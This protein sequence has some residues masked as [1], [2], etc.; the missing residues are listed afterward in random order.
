MK[1]LTQSRC[2]Q[3]AAILNHRPRKRLGFLTPLERLQDLGLF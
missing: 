3:I 1:N 2:N